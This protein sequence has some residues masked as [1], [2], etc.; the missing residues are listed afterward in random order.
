[1]RHTITV[2]R[3]LAA[4]IL[5][6]GL[7]T[8]VTNAQQAPQARTF[9]HSVGGWSLIEVKDA[10]DNIIGFWGIPRVAVEV[11]NIRRLWFEVLPNDQWDVW[12]F[13]PVAINDKIQTLIQAGATSEALQF[14]M[15]QESMAA[16]T[17]I[18]LDV[19]GGV[20]GLVVKGFIA[21]DPL[22]DAAG[23]LADPNPMIDLL[24]DVGYPIAPGMTDLMVDG[25]AGANVG[26]NPATK[27]TLNCLRS[28]DSS[29]GDCICTRAEL[30]VVV[31]PWTV[32]ELLQE[33]RLRCEYTRTES[34]FYWQWGKYSDNCVECTEGTADEPLQYNIIQE[35]TEYW[36]DLT[37][38]PDAPMFDFE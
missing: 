32:F 12:A 20:D 13:E 31:S 18:N 6:L 17:A 34:H 23:A 36:Y 19:D 3:L 37:Q 29:C 10:T 24:A 28:L 1:M 7:G 2:R 11:G 9:V 33:G 8:S 38:C 30:P 26:M 27:V 15:S 21:G 5:A 16:D 25:T 35:T 22:A 14:L 4:G